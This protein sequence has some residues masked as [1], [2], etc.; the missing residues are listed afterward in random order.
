MSSYMIPQLLKGEGDLLLSESESGWFASIFSIACLTGA[1]HG[2]YVSDR[3]GRKKSM[4]IDCLGYIIGFLLIGFAPNFYVLILGRL[5]TGHFASSSVISAPILVGETSNPSLRGFTGTLLSILYCVGYTASM[6]T[7]AV[8][9]WRT[10]LLVFTSIPALSIVL[11]LCIKES[12]SWLL[13]QGKKE[14]AYESLMFY[15]G[16]ELVVQAEMQ[17]IS[18]TISKQNKENEFLGDSTLQRMKNKLRRVVSP[19]F[20]KPFSLLILMSCLG[21]EWGGFPAL[22][23]YL[24]SILQEVHIPMDPNLVAIILAAYRTVLVLC[25]FP[26]INKAPRRKM[27]LL[28]GVVVALALFIQSSYSLAA[29]AIPLKIQEYSKWTPMVSILIQYTGYSMGW[30][31]LLMNFLGEILPSD[32]RSTGAAMLGIL[33]N[34]AT[35]S[36]VR[37]IPVIISSFGPGGLFGVYFICVLVVLFLCSLFM[38]ETKG[39]SLEDIEDMYSKSKKDSPIQEKV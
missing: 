33:Q 3:L 30:G 24:H 17:R 36:A 21:N 37:M 29:P 12:P 8:L 5:I 11:L 19:G 32:M 27:Y 2:G 1:L 7:G 4:L 10:A 13:R 39:M 15:R 20:L 31:V 6:V 38:P 22:S 28:S 25:L 23:Y 34:V 16:N 14:A 18:E 35:F 26:I 9:P